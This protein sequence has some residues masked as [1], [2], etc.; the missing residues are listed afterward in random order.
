MA[1]VTTLTAEQRLQAEWQLLEAL[2]F[3]CS[4]S[5]GSQ[6]DRVLALPPRA[7]AQA[8]YY[9]DLLGWLTPGPP[10]GF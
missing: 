9:L 1:G 4:F 6:G 3:F 7:F 8:A 2:L 10:D 5:D